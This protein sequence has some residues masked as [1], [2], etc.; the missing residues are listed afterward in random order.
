MESLG[1]KLHFWDQT[2]SKGAAFLGSKLVD[3]VQPHSLMKTL[4]TSFLHLSNI[5]RYS[6]WD[7][8]LHSQQGSSMYGIK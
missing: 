3:I 5:P 2:Q 8:C 7:A 1:N 4:D 6:N